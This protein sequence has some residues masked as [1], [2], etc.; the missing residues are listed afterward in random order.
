MRGG[1]G[2]FGIVTSF[3]YRLHEVGP[4]LGGGVLYP[5]DKA[6]DVLHFYRDFAAN[7]PDELSTQIGRLTTLDGIPVIGVAGCYC[8]SLAEG[9][10][11]L[12]PLRAFGAP[13]R[14]CSDRSAMSRCRACSIRGFRRPAGLL[15]GQLSPWS[16]R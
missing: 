3:E 2:N 7:S 13:L 12:A 10:K 9:E 15:E 11:A 4:V 8:G 1:G 14:I 16:S 6:R 5:V